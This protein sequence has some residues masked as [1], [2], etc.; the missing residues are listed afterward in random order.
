MGLLI[1]IFFALAAVILLLAYM[2]T[3]KV[4]IYLPKGGLRWLW[5]VLIFLFSSGLLGAIVLIIL[6]NTISFER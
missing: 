2:I 4:S 3:H 5:Q 6:A 1:L